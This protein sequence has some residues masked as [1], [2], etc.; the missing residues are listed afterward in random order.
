MSDARPTPHRRRFRFW[1][2]FLLALVLVVELSGAARS[3]S[4]T[5]DEAYHMLAGWRYWTARDFGINSEHPPLVKQLA[6]LPLL[7]LHPQ[8]PSVPRGTSKLESFV[9]ARKFLYANDADALLVWCR[10]AATLFTLFL[11]LLLFEAAEQMFGLLAGLA[12]LVLAVFEPNLLAHGALVTTDVA[13]ACC[14][15]AAVYAFYRYLRR[16]SVLRLLECGFTAGLSL[17]V[18]H[19]G[20]LVFPILGL[21]TAAEMIIGRATLPHDPGTLHLDLRA[22]ARRAL[23]LAGALAVI[24]AVALLVLWSAYTFRFR[25]RPAPLEMTPPLADYVQGVGHQPL[26]NSMEARAI[27]T[28]A[29]WKLL[30]EAYLYGLADVL[31]VSEGPRPTFIFG[32]LYP[33]ARWYY[34]P[35]AFLI[36]SSLGFLLLLL[37]APAAQALRSREARREILFLTIPPIVYLAFS[38]TSGLN[39]G[40]RHILPIYPFLLVLAAGAAAALARRQRRWAYIICALV[41]LHVAASLHAYPDY[42]PFSNLA[43]GGPAKTYRVLSDSNVDWG[44]GLKAVKAYL[45]RRHIQDCWLA[46]FGSADPDDYHIPC[47][48]LPDDFTLWWGKPVEVVP[49]TYDGTVLISATELNGTYTG[50]DG[51]NP[52]ASFQKIRP[53]ANI[54]GAVLAYEGRFELS[55]AAALSR[56]QHAWQ[57]HMQG[58]AGEAIAEA[59]TSVALAPRMTYAHYMLGNLLAITRQ[60][61]EARQEYEAALE[62]ARA[63]DPQYQWFWIPFL[64]A[65]MKQL[66]PPSPPTR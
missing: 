54:A 19:S 2:V 39:V 30:P 9:T 48:T 37:L 11:A 57:F 13:A 64:Q 35:G 16:P 1:A 63:N 12:A 55:E 58:R 5:W 36:K 25:A 41:G 49:Q 10:M 46:N 62:L 42:T 18:K 60:S 4:Q 61:E 22:A 45:D 56:A 51:L 33:S 65:R 40:I 17:A 59:R 38:M 31:T 21:L 52:Y 50:P 32:N 20:L 24:L 26:R 15:F 3:E 47:K 7:F 6:T 44:Q 27:L 28:L 66:P 8:A 29:R 53:A 43:W 14:L 34:F 23:R